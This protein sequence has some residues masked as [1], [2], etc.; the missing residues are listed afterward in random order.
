MRHLSV[1]VI[2]FIKLVGGR[3]LHPLMTQC[4]VC[5]QMVRLHVDK[6]GRR[7]VFA[8]ARELY[9]EFRLS[10]HYAAKFKCV[11]SGSRR[12]FDPRPNERQRFKLPNSLLEE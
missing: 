4:P 8:H 9:E 5:K 7:H 1:W 6:A 12:L 3:R 11:G 2:E 10:I